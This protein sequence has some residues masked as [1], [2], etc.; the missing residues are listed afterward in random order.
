LRAIFALIL[1]SAPQ[2]DNFM[3]GLWTIT[4]VQALACREFG[5]HLSAG[6]ATRLME[7]L[8]LHP[9]RLLKMSRTP[10]PKKVVDWLT[11]EL[12]EIKRMAKKVGASLYF[13]KRA[14]CQRWCTS[15]VASDGRPWDAQ[16]SDSTN[17][18]RIT[19]LAAFDVKGG[20]RFLATGESFNADVFCLF[21]SRLLAEA[22]A[23]IFLVVDE[24]VVSRSKK[25]CAFVGSSEG[26][27]RLFYRNQRS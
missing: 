12:P 15:A 17:S 9:R 24:H 18:R 16:V 5:V 22:E 10:K 1:D 23:P 11:T 4:A 25:V 13:G 14:C 20:S 27:L 26:K 19:L 3:E 6:A 8:G 2:L 7:K 21:L